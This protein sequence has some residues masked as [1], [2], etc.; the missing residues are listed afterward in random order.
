MGGRAVL[1]ATA[2]G[3]TTLAVGGAGIGLMGGTNAG[4][5]AP[6]LTR[7]TGGGAFC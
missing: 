4:G 5:G 2:G 1:L 3:A 7:G 6:Q